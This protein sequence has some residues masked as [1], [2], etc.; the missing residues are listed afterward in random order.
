[1]HR[2]HTLAKIL[3]ETAINCYNILSKM[4]GTEDLQRLTMVKYSV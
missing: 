1:M 4:I 2:Y 3:E